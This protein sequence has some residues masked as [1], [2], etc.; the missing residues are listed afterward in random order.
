MESRQLTSRERAIVELLLSATFSGR[1][2]I[3]KQVRNARVRVVDPEGSLAFEVSASEKAAVRHRIPIE[4]EA[5]DRDGVTVHALLH[6]VDGRVAE[7]EFFKDDAS[8][9]LELPP[10]DQWRLIELHG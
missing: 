5:E 2:A 4:A 3:R 8:P 9:I 10:P 7:L 6:V 1:E